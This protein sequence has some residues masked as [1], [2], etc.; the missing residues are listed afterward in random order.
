MALHWLEQENTRGWFD[1]EFRVSPEFTRSPL[2][3]CERNGAD[4]ILDCAGRQIYR[5]ALPIGEHYLSCF[6]YIFR[7]QS[8]NRALRHSYAFRSLK[9]SRRLHQYGFHTYRCLAA[10]RPKGEFLNWN[11]VLVASEIRA[12]FE[13]PS[14]GNHIYMVH[15]STPFTSSVARPLAVELSRFHDKG[16]FH[17]DLKTR[18]ILVR[19]PGDLNGEPSFK[20]FFVDLEKTR[21]LSYLPTF[22]ADLLT[23]R[24]LIQFFASLCDPKRGH[25][26]SRTEGTFLDW[27]L[28]G[29]NLTPSRE[30]R[31]RKMVS[32][33]GPQGRLKQG[34]TLVEGLLSVLHTR[35]DSA[36]ADSQR[37]WPET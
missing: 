13:L 4:H 20:F 6:V 1:E 21:H 25:L 31:I 34:E 36:G 10:F 28:E 7:N 15:P 30:R 2:Q 19:P 37:G 33:Y 23:A 18:H 12:V 5:I 11:G 29:R 24:D 3:F 8:L 14:S 35:K 17:G 26:R 9:I 27:Y 22:A 32:L 16:F